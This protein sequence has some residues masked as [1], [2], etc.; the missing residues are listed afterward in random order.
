MGLCPSSPTAAPCRGRGWPCSCSA[1]RA[2]T[3]PRDPAGLVLGCL[4]RGA[5]QPRDV[6]WPLSSGLSR[7]VLLMCHIFCISFL[8][9][10]SLEPF[11]GM[12]SSPARAKFPPDLPCPLSCLPSFPLPC[13]PSFPLSCLMLTAVLSWWPLHCAWPC[14]CTVGPHGK[15]PRLELGRSSVGYRDWD[16][17]TAPRVCVEHVCA[18]EH[19]QLRLP[20]APA[21]WCWD[22]ALPRD[23]GRA[24]D[25]KPG[26]VPQI[27]P[28]PCP[29]G[30]VPSRSLRKDGGRREWDG[31]SSA[32]AGFQPWMEQ[33]SPG[34]NPCSAGAQRG[35]PGC[36]QARP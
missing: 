1:G 8:I 34:T 35:V 6:L 4:T 19:G 32:S 7:M 28:M 29:G 16:K 26:P 2:P 21:A 10:P 22:P 33:P 14:P 25:R 9:P 18:H 20:G 31:S 30:A 5:A 23:H 27:C 17:D 3:P 15:G 12:S 13:C 24:G 36:T 11:L